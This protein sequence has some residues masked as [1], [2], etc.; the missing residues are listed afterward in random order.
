MVFA[1]KNGVCGYAPNKPI[2][3]D[4][5]FDVSSGEVLCILGANGAGKS[6]LFKSML[7]LIPILNGVLTVD[8]E[9]IAGWS[10]AEIART[11][12]Y[13][14]QANNP[15][16]S[17]S[18]L[19]VILMGRTAYLGLFASPK[20]EDEEIAE[21][22]IRQLNISRLVDKRYQELSGGEK[23]LVLIARALAQLPKILIMDEPTAALD[24]GNQQMVLNQIHK[25]SQN[26][27]SI[28]MASHFPDHAFLYSHKALLLKDG[29]IYSVGRPNDVITEESLRDLYAV[30]TKII[31]TGIQP[32]YA[33]TDAS[34]IKICVP[35]S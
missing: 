31:N 34:D 32:R 29:G 16:F 23:Q 1:L 21:D 13:I 33:A 19:D 25:L 15:P 2:L 27:L 28:I 9:S 7:G 35:L 18:V 5:N 26:G 30:E 22:A 17:Y 4:I 20:K 3:K 14:P 6:T 24:F 8:N 11:I 12:G 10:R